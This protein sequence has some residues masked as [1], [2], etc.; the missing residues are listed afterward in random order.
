MHDNDTETPFQ[1]S[2]DEYNA[3][4][5][6]MNPY[7]QNIAAT[8]SKSIHGREELPTALCVPLV[9]DDYGVNSTPII[10]DATTVTETIS[11]NLGRDPVAIT[12]PFCHYYGRT[13]VDDKFD[14]GSW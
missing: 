6:P 14:L 5:P 10:N 7:Y 1:G 11:R 13:V 8:E 12:C 4:T 9:T 3:P 2:I